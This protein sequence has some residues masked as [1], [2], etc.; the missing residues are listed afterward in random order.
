MKHNVI[1]NGR[2]ITFTNSA[3]I[4]Y[5]HIF[6][7]I[8]CFD[9]LE[10]QSVTENLSIIIVTTFDSLMSVALL[11]EVNSYNIKVRFQIQFS[12]TLKNVTFKQI[13]LLITNVVCSAY[14]TFSLVSL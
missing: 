14:I 10:K 11:I 3:Y 2:I 4:I 5:L 8:I 9:Q 13:M 1:I 7:N 6:G 12:A